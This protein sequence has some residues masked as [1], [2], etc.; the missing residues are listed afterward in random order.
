MPDPL[1]KALKE[2]A[3]YLKNRSIYLL[4]NL[5]TTAALFCGFYAII[6]AMGGYFRLAAMAIFIAMIFDGLDGRIARWTQTESPFGAEYDSLS[7]MVSF[8]VAPRTGRLRM[9]PKRRWQARLGCRLHLLRRDSAPIG[10]VQHQRRHHRQTLLPR[11]TKPG[12]GGCHRIDRLGAA[13][14]RRRACSKPRRFISRL[15]RYGFCRPL[16]DQQHPLPQWQV[17][18]LP[19]KRAGKHDY[20]PGR[21]HRFDR[22][23]RAQYRRDTPGTLRTLRNFRAVDRPVA[24]DQTPATHSKPFDRQIKPRQRSK[25]RQQTHRESC[26]EDQNRIDWQP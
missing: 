14:L 12:S 23:V 10:P 8:G 4:P 6:V 24:I 13:Q 11:L 2:R 5:F 25:N 21:R 26:T 17:A 7:D 3:A 9:G 20:D 22:C 15:D 18:E 1:P 19:K 16:D